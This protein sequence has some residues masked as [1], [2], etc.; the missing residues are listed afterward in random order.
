[1]DTEKKNRFSSLKSQKSSNIFKSR[2]PNHDEDDSNNRFVRKR[3]EFNGKRDTHSNN[4]FA[5]KPE[6]NDSSR[7]QQPTRQLRENKRFSTFNKRNNNN[8]YNN[9]SDRGNYSNGNSYNSRTNSNRFQYKKRPYQKKNNYRSKMEHSNFDPLNPNGNSLF[10][11]I[12][13]QKKTVK[14]NI[15][16]QEKNTKTKLPI[17]KKTDMQLDKKNKIMVIQKNGDLVKKDKLEEDVDD[18]TTN[19]WLINKYNY[20]SESSE[21]DSD[22]ED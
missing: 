16:Q 6:Y 12:I 21:E 20:V 18:D 7:F 13:E 8:N 22:E 4:R 9:N 2:R 1:M 19:Q 3:F 14:N 17:I 11:N 10:N 5:R 15:T